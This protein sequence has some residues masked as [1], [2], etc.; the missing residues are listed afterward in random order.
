MAPNT[1]P[2]MVTIFSAAWWLPGSVAPVQSVSSRHSYPRSLASRIVVCTHMSVVMPVRMRWVTP[3]VRS[4][5]SRS[6]A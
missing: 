2:C 1:P 3:R 6:V 4:T 5:R